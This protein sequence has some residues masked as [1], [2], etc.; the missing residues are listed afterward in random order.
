MISYATGGGLS[1]DV[2][3]GRRRATTPTLESLAVGHVFS[4][5]TFLPAAAPLGASFAESNPPSSFDHSKRLLG[6]RKAIQTF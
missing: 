3:G 5:L 1:L 2:S 4:L 6:D